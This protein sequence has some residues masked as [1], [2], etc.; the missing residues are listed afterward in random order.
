MLYDIKELIEKMK[1]ISSSSTNVALAQNLDVSYN[2]LNTWIKRGKFPQE[3]LLDFCK[4][5]H[6]SLDY[7][8]LSNEDKSPTLANSQNESTHTNN[9][10]KDDTHTAFSFLGQ[11]EHLNIKPGDQITI[12]KK[13]L[14]SPAYYLLL[15]DR[16]YFISKVEI[17]PFL[18]IVVLDDYKVKITI[19]E[20]K[21]I[22]VG[23]IEP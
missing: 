18:K 10:I 20:F 8:L 22:K 12:N 3:V 9:E 4:K 6:C 7:L 17:D 1:L 19:D 16:T 23:L 2:T 21:K 5:Y 15:K 13:L 11:Y 14:F